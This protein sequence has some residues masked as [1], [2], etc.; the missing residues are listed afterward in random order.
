MLKGNFVPIALNFGQEF[1]AQDYVSYFLGGNPVC[2]TVEHKNAGEKI[3]SHN[4]KGDP[5]QSWRHGSDGK[6]HIDGHNYHQ[7]TTAK[8]LILSHFFSF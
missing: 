2:I 4:L 1:W 6:S 3:D 7:E 8:V 5:D